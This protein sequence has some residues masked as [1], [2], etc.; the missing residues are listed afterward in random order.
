MRNAPEPEGD[1]DQQMIERALRR[2][3][4]EVV[5]QQRQPQPPQRAQLLLQGGR[6]AGAHLR[7]AQQTLPNPAT[8]TTREFTHA[9]AGLPTFSTACQSRNLKDIMV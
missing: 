3:P 6:R 7:T 4:A 1:G 2:C 9:I 5:V 8:Y